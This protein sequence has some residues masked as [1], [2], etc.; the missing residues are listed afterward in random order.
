MRILVNWFAHQ[1]MQVQWGSSVSAPFKVNYGKTSS[2]VLFI[3][4]IYELYK[5][6]NACNTGCMIGFTLVNYTMY[7][8]D[9]VVFSSTQR[10]GPALGLTFL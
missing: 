7:A 6:L 1:I 9:L 2:L 5:G 8:D 10:L 3:L 4:Y